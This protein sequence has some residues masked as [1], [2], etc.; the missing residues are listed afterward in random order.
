MD[1]TLHAPSTVRHGAS[2][3]MPLTDPEQDDRRRCSL[4]QRPSTHSPRDPDVASASASGSDA[5][6]EYHKYIMSFYGKI[7]ADS[8]TVHVKL[9]SYDGYGMY[10]QRP[11]HVNEVVFEEAPAVSV[12]VQGALEIVLTDLHRDLDL[13]QGHEGAN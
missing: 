8:D 4:E 12:Q 2:I 11:I 3:D 9:G 7:L 5:L 10:A 6:N 1:E 13:L